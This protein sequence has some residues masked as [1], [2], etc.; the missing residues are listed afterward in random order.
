MRLYLAAA[1][2][3][4]LSL[5]LVRPLCWCIVALARVLGTL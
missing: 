4:A 3:V 2:L 1:C 5:A